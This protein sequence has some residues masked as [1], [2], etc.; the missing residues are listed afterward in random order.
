ML[1]LAGGCGAVCRVLL[2]EVVASRWA[3]RLPWG[4]IVVNVTGSLLLGLVVG[5][6][7][8]EVVRSVVGVGFLG[9]Y[10]TFS[11]ASLQSVVLLREGRRFAGVVNMF[12][13]AAAATAAAG[14]GMWLAG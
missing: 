3:R 14:A 2:D 11:T 1:S 5:A 12:G 6:A 10:T 8:P 13:V 4:T 9:G 7:V